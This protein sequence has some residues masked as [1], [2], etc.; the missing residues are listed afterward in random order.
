MLSV[1]KQSKSSENYMMKPHPS[2]CESYPYLVDHIDNGITLCKNCHVKL[3][4][5]E[6]DTDFLIEVVV[7]PLKEQMDRLNQTNRAIQR[8]TKP[9]QSP[10]GTEER[11]NTQQPHTDNTSSFG[12]AHTRS[13]TQQP[14]VDRQIASPIVIPVQFDKIGTSF[15]EGFVWFLGQDGKFGFINRNV[16][17]VIPAQFDDLQDFRDGLARFKQGKKYGFINRNGEVVIPAQFDKVGSF[18]EGFAGFSDPNGKS[19]FIDRNG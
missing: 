16:E 10:I 3:K 9:D 6:N 14:N 7:Q 4:N 17:I 12:S 15:S 18:S 13:T 19:G 1:N 11:T 5:K 8:V 2:K